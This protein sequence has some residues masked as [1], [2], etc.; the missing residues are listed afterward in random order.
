[1]QHDPGI[2]PFAQWLETHT[3]LTLGQEKWAFLQNRLG[4]RMGDLGAK[5]LQAY[6]QI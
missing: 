2:I 3:G 4:D 1:M 5:D 6:L